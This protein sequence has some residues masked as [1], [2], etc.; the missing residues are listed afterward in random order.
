[1]EGIP[2]AIE[3]AAVRVPA[4][5]V[6]QIAELLADR[7][8]LLSR[9]SRLDSPRHQTLRATLDWSYALLDRNEQRLFERLAAFTGGWDLEAANAVCAWE[10]LAPH[11]F[12]TVW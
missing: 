1:L 3:L 5:G 4:L 9:G 7:L 12:W 2:L 10:P 11:G 8:G 6:A